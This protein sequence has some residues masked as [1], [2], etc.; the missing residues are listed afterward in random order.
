M[1]ALRHVSRGRHDQIG[2]NVQLSSLNRL[3][4]PYGQGSSPSVFATRVA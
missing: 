4:H 1:P 3:I 2:S